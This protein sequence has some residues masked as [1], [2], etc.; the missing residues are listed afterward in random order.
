MSN[1][2][3]LILFTIVGAVLTGCAA[4][5]VKHTYGGALTELYRAGTPNIEAYPNYTHRV[6]HNCVSQPIYDNYGYYV[7][8]DVRCW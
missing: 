5:P 3:K 6:S 8:T 7:R 1:L 4:Q 2:T